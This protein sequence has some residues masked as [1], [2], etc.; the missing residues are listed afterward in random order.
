MA[1]NME[2]REGQLRPLQPAHARE[3]RLHTVRLPRQAAAKFDR[4]R[5]AGHRFVVSL[6]PNQHGGTVRAQTATLWRIGAGS[7]NLD[8]LTTAELPGVQGGLVAAVDA[9]EN[10]RLQLTVEAV[11]AKS[12]PVD[13]AV[14]AALH[15]EGISWRD[16]RG[17]IDDAELP[18]WIELQLLKHGWQA[19]EIRQL[20]RRSVS[21]RRAKMHLAEC[22]V[23]V[24]ALDP[25]LASES[26]R[27]GIGRGRSFGA[28]MLTITTT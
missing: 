1:Q 20:H 2:A 19:V 18:A 25:A 15:A 4:D 6:L 5:D 3:S 11:R 8:I 23:D 7:D 17:R 28:G 16:P 14:A 22:V 12:S 13:P 21:R 10:V 9:G 26:L 24:V 27:S